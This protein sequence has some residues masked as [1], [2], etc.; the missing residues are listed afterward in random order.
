MDSIEETL[1][2]TKDYVNSEEYELRLKELFL[3][4]YLALLGAK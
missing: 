3:K 4:R 1:K 2:A